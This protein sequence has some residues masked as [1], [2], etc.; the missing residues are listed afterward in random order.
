LRNQI[1]QDLEAAEENRQR[2]EKLQEVYKILR[3]RLDFDIPGT[4]VQRL[5][6]Q[7]I[8]RTEQ[9]LN[10]YGISLKNMT[11]DYIDQYL[12]KTQNESRLEAKNMLI[13][14]QVGRFLS[15]EATEEMVDAEI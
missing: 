8:E 7:S 11:S 4:L 2:S 3:N 13:A 14:E 15:I 10:Q 6:N 1:R 5:A 12:H 9:Q